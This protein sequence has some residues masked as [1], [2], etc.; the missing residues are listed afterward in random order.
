MTENDTL[1]FVS[2][3]SPKYFI[4]LALGAGCPVLPCVSRLWFSESK[5]KDLMKQGINGTRATVHSERP[6]LSW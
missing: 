2:I 1:I 4:N 3:Y 6:G 5:G